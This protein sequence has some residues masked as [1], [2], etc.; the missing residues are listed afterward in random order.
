MCS[1]MLIIDFFKQ[2][3]F[4]LGEKDFGKKV[5]LQVWDSRGEN[6]LKKKGH[7]GK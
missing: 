2:D 7:V 4:S 6:Y 1:S 3:N 5:D